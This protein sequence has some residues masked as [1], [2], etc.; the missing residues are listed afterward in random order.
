M[1]NYYKYLFVILPLILAGKI[2]NYNV[3]GTYVSE[4]D[5]FG[6]TKLTIKSD[7][8]FNEVV[9]GCIYDFRT[10]GKWVQNRDTIILNIT[11][12]VNLKSKCS[13]EVLNR[14]EKYLIKT[15]TLFLLNNENVKS[16]YTLIRN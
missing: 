2:D 11:K 8:Y 6:S 15:D 4:R 13:M 16:Y 5:V 12:R 10:T 14:I 7:G 3:C 1:R 9:S